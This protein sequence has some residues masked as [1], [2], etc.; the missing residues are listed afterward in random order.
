[1]DLTEILT[2]IFTP[3]DADINAVVVIARIILAII[4][5]GLIGL[6]RGKHGSA[7]GLRTHIMVCIGSCVAALTGL[8]AR[9]YLPE[10]YTADIF[11]LA[12]QVISG[13]GFLGAGMI[14]VKNSNIITGL[15]TAAGMWATAT[16]GIALGFGFCSGAFFATVACIFTAAFLTKFERKRKMQVNLYAEI[17]DPKYAGKIF[18][19]IHNIVS[20]DVLIDIV[21]SK[22]GINGHLAIFITIS[23]TED[24]TE[25]R[26]K[27]SSMDG[28][29]FVIPG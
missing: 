20:D 5:G 18:D 16:I 3:N 28:I 19:D 15:T 6:E 26:E 4:A 22:S 27:I 29:S 21:N 23:N 1:M 25:L 9:A 7:A 10:V 17:S 12:A 13:I 24:Y 8:Y 11:R 14:I 2:K